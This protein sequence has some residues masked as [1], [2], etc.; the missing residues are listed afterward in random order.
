MNTLLVDMNNIDKLEPSTTKKSSSQCRSIGL[1]A[2]GIF[3]YSSFSIATAAPGGN[4]SNPKG[5]PFVELNG[6]VVAV[7]AL[8]PL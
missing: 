5:K 6:Q 3:L 2:L 8:S 1:F 7:E 4:G